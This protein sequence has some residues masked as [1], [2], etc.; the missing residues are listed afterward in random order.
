MLWQ[1]PFRSHAPEWRNAPPERLFLYRAAKT[2]LTT[3]F[4]LVKA[5]A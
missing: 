2:L 1:R 4:S 3:I 5:C